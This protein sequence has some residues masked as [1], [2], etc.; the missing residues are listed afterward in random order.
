MTIEE[1]RA[2]VEII[3]LRQKKPFQI[4]QALLEACSA[5]LQWRWI[6]CGNILLDKKMAKLKSD[7]ALALPCQRRRGR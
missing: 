1:Q 3:T 2:L 6:Q 5:N 7:G 4:R